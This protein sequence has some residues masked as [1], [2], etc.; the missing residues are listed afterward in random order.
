MDETTSSVPLEQQSDEEL[1]FRRRL[2]DAICRWLASEPDPRAT[3]AFE[4][5]RFQLALIDAEI[6]RRDRLVSP[7]PESVVV[8][9]QAGQLFAKS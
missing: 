7:E 8:G 4:I 2:C 5:Y 3:R 1:Q 6:T 9:L